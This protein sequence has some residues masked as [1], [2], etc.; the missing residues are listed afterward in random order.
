MTHTAS[1]PKCAAIVLG[2]GASRRMGQPKALLPFGDEPLIAHVVRTCTQVDFIYSTIVVSG[3][4]PARIAD[5]VAP[6]DVKIVHNPDFDSDGM[7]SSIRV[8]LRAVHDV[9]AVFIVLGDQPLVARAT[10]E[11]LARAINETDRAIARPVYRGHHG[12]PILMGSGCV[13][14]IL[15]LPLDAT[16]SDFV[17]GHQSHVA[18]VPVD[19][20]AILLDVD[21][22]DDYRRALK[23]LARRDRSWT[24]Q[25]EAATK[26]AAG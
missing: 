26:V 2:A 9:D 15:Q 23:M 7:I 22:P 4:L 13:C 12:H 20:E 1:L 3:H 24:C 16:L 18:D 10:F 5:A 17:H 25:D 8:G 21:T 14:E 19:D 11:G 6:F